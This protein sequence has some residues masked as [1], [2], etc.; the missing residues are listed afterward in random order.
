MNKKIYI[1]GIGGI[2]ISAIARYYNENGYQVFWSDSTDSELIQKLQSEWIYITTSPLT[3]LLWGEGDKIDLVIYTEAIP[4]NNK[5]LLLA[6]ELWIEVLTYPE[7][8]A[9]IANN[10]KLVA[11]A[12]THG[13]ST[14]TSLSSLLLKGSPLWVN[15]VIWT[16]LKEFQW[17]NS[18]FSKSDYFVIEACEYKRSFL[19][20]TPLIGIITNIEIDHLDYYKDLEDY[21]LAYKEFIN[22]IKTGWYIIIN[23]ED[24]NCQT[25]IWLRDDITYIF[26]FQEYFLLNREKIYFPKIEMQVPGQHILFDAKLS[27]TL[28]I[29]LWLKEKNIISCLEQYTWVWRR[30]EI[31]GQ[32]KNWNILMSDYGHH[33]TEIQLTLKA[34][35]EKYPEKELLTI[36]QPHQYNRT[37]EL[38]EGFKT[39]F[40][41]TD[42]LIIPDIYESRD[43][44]DDKRKISSKTLVEAIVHNNK[45][46]GQWQNNTLSLIKNYEITH[47]KDSIILLLWAWDIDNFRYQIP[48]K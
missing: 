21:I 6:W 40:T 37:L 2:G 31:I 44:E 35:K 41:Y 20:Y 26:V 29:I 46:D 45:I 34:L 4:K 10:K 15:A 22:N 27:F 18:Y 47:K 42:T 9:A 39:S 43:T 38:L 24:K 32:T 33:P 28:W 48:M 5:E 8:L 14:T 11:V 36:F 25:L 30:M 13:K 1:I 3:P 16:I 7:A 17:K 12:G 19:K 23:G